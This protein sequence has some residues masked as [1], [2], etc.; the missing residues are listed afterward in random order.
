MIIEHNSEFPTNSNAFVITIT[1]K[2]KWYLVEAA[3]N[4]WLLDLF[5]NGISHNPTIEFDNKQAAIR[6]IEREEK[7]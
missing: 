2:R 6:H 3:Q 1:P 5:V 4:W 7:V